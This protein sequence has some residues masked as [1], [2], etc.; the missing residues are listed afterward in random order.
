V[1][2]PL[3]TYLHDHLFGADFAIDLLKAMGDRHPEEQVQRFVK[4]LLAGLE[5]DRRA[6]REIA[7]KV[8]SGRSTVKEVAAWLGE[9]ASRAK[10][11]SACAT[12]FAEFEAVEFL[13]LGILGKM[14][15]WRML[16]VL[17]ETDCRLGAID[18]QTL[19][20]RASAQFDR[21]E[22]RRIEVS[23]LAFAPQRGDAG[24]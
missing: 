5:E 13:A 1:D 3:G 4:P 6:L 24:P 16:Q 8:G 21:V 17:S 10:L 18:L 20:S 2:N 9:K 22:A 12:S 11:G 14:A 19:I 23:L 7:K 15:L